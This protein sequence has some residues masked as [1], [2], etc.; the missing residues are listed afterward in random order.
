MAR[1]IQGKIMI[2]INEGVKRVVLLREKVEVSIGLS[3]DNVSLY[4]LEVVKEG[5]YNFRQVKE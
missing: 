1:A 5:E 4:F 3:I 2:C